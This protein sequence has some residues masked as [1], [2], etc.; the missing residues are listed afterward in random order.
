[1]GGG[2]YVTF[3][4]LPPFLAWAAFREKNGVRSLEEMERRMEKYRVPN[5]MEGPPLLG[6]TVLTEPF[7]FRE[8]DWIPLPNWKRTTV[9]GKGFSTVEEE[10]R[11]IWEQ[12][13]ERLP[14]A[15]SSRPRQVAGG[16][17]GLR[18]GQG[19]FRVVV[20]DAWQRRCAISGERALPVPEA[21]HIVPCT[22]QGPNLASNGLLLRADLHRLFALGYLTVTRD[23]RVEV[24]P[25]LK[26]DW[27]EG[28]QYGRWQGQ[29]LGNL[30]EDLSRRPDPKYLEWHNERIYRG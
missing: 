30:P 18:L 17:A 27:G 10:G 6:C 9:R 14:R 1:M 19:G 11:R 23:W 20:T 5:R 21:A 16:E 28:T 25:H 22:S 24:S 29:P 7:W 12:V 15:I 2:Y 3:T 4:R 26:E 8:A 13:R